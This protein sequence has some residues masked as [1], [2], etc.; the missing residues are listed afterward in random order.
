MGFSEIA[1]NTL[2][3]FGETK[4]EPGFVNISPHYSIS[5]IFEDGFRFGSRTY[6]S[7]QVATGGGIS[8]E[9]HSWFLNPTDESVPGSIYPFGSDFDTRSFDNRL[10]HNV[11]PQDMGVFFDTNAER[12]SVVVTWHK[13]GRFYAQHE[14][15][16]T[17]QLEM[18]D[19]GH[20]DAEVIFRFSKIPTSG[21]FN[22]G[23][24]PLDGERIHVTAA[25]LGYRPNEIDREEGN[26]GVPGVW[27]FKVIDGAVVATDPLEVTEGP[28]VLTGSIF[29]DV[30]EGG[31][32]NDSIDGDVS[33]DRILGGE[34]DDFLL[35]GRGNDTLDG[36]DGDDTVEGGLG[37]D[38]IG[39]GA[40]NDLLLEDWGDYIPQRDTING[41]DGNDTIDGARG[42]DILG[43]QSGDDVIRGGNGDDLIGGGSG[44]D[45]LSGG[46]GNDSFWGGSGDDFIYGDRGRN[47]ATGGEGAD[48]FLL[49]AEGILILHDFNPDEGDRLIVD[50][51]RWAREMFD[52]RTDG[53]DQSGT[54]ATI[55]YRMAQ[56]TAF[57]IV[58]E[59]H[60]VDGMESLR[61]DVPSAEGTAIDPLIWDLT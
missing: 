12:D 61:L 2:L 18:I 31:D 9:G 40:G 13:V 53:S 50:G 29:P 48:T 34:G 28:D 51:D 46:R 27:Q 7:L 17:F 55:L 6:D 25:H 30:M 39:G 52:I 3:P 47:E 22:L 19:T 54:T 59:I 10:P 35:G 60:A 33:E 56:E 36:G 58:A 26:T 32:G 16:H 42:N 23:L 20:G 43:G 38:S 41:N 49:T 57:R 11:G 24:W 37:Y 45:I 8:F 4:M 44:N 5:G 15:S 14:F 21:N 1:D